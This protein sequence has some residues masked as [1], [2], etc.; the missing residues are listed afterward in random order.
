MN[1]PSQSLDVATDTLEELNDWVAKIREV[2]QNA[3]ARMQEGKI[4]ERRK[5]IALELSELVVYC[6]PVPFDEESKWLR[7][8]FC[9]RTG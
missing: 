7:P 3:D 9:F 2:T 8:N 4:M 6:R 1:H 5:K